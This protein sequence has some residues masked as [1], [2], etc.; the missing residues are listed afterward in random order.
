MVP[1]DTRL[2]K[3]WRTAEIA[4][5]QRGLILRI[6]NE[7]Q[8]EKGEVEQMAKQLFGVGVKEVNKMQA[9]QLI[10]ELLEK[11]AK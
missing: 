4:D 2:N 8:V 1:T 5:G 7:N 9:S 10:E 3:V 11:L 6:V